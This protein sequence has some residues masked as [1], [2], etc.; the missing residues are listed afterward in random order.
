MLDPQ[1]GE[2]VLDLCAAPGI[3]TTAIAARM[4]D[5]GEVVAVELDPGRARRAAR[6]LRAAG[7]DLRQRGRGRRRRGRPRRRLRSRAGGS[8]LL[9]PRDAR[10][11]PRRALAKVARADR[12]RSAGSRARSWPGPPRRSAPGGTLVY[13]TCT[14]SR[15]ENEGRI[16]ALGARAARLRRRRPGRRHPG[17]ASPARPPL[18]ADAAR[19]RP[20]RRVLHRPAARGAGS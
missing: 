9:R 14:I 13:S 8:A 17:L 7:R 5:R 3:K 10:L 2:R 11:A 4:R 20:H 6:A 19:P 18:P 1:P 12:A 15:R 16:A